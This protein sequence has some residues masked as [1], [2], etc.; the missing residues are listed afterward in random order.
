M[1]ELLHRIYDFLAAHDFPTI[2]E[3]LRKIEWSQAARSPYLWLIALPIAICL[4]W[5]KK[6]KLI[7]ALVS[8]FLFLLLIQKTLTPASGT[9]PLDDLLIFLSGAVLLVGIN[10]YLIFVKD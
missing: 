6:Y 1:K 10:F 7:T 8:F 9:L 5:T 2:L 4:I 3:S